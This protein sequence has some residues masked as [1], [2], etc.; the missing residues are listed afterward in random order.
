TGVPESYLVAPNGLV[1]TGF[2]G[3]VTAAALDEAIE[4]AG[5]MA[6]AVSS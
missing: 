2:T 6:V 4:N 3:G 5:G 1:V